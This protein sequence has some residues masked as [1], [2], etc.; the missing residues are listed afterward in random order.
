[1][2][3]GHGDEKF[4]A[5]F[6]CALLLR[7][8]RLPLPLLGAG[9]TVAVFSAPIAVYLQPYSTYALAPFSW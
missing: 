6:G 2:Q 4:V 1:L 5:A 7:D 9:V 8:R 3:A